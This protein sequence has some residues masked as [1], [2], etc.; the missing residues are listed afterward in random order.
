MG[1][2]DR[3]R[4]RER[5]IR[6]YRFHPSI[7][8]KLAQQHPHLDGRQRAE[9]ME[10]L[11]DWFLVCLRR[12]RRE[13]V[14]MPSRLVDDA[15]H[16]FIIHTREYADFC[17]RAFG[18]ILHHAPEQVVADD[19]RMNSGMRRTWM[20]SCA[21]S[22][23][24]PARAAVI[25]RLFAIDAALMVSGAYIVGPA[26][27]PFVDDR[28]Q[29]T[30]AAGGCGAACGSYGDGGHHGGDGGGGDGGGGCGGGGCGGGCGG[31]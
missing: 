13:F 22:G 7:E 16:A 21:L 30:G 19:R 14:S 29:S 1:I 10:G 9:V 23:Q 18:R 25:P 24:D 31:G 6:A 2:F 8:A 17:K 20:Y 12:R 15:W 3:R 11:R 5:F 26:G 4:S 28:D 27:P